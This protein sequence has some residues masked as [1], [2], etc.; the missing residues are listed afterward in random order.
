MQVVREQA[1]S[2][3]TLTTAVRY[4]LETP[5]NQ[6]LLESRPA[7]WSSQATIRDLAL[8]RPKPA[9]STQ[10]LRPTRTIRSPAPPLVSV[11]SSVIQPWLSVW[12]PPPDLSLPAATKPLLPP[13]PSGPPRSYLPYNYDDDDCE[14][15]PPPPREISESPPPPSPVESYPVDL[16]VV[17]GDCL[18]IDYS[19]PVQEE[20]EE[21]EDDDVAQDDVVR[22]EIVEEGDEQDLGES[23]DSDPGYAEECYYSDQNGSGYGP[24]PEDEDWG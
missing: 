13:I 6:P 1:D 8:V 10:V 7:S 17:C 14:P 16:Y 5:P 24:E 11:H 23:Y 15:P 18:G 12:T 2:I 20:L 9:S 21:E 3:R 19:E 22:D 4:L